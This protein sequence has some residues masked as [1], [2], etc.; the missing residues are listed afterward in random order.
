MV[1]LNASLA[2]TLVMII[3]CTMVTAVTEA[4]HCLF[5]MRQRGLKRMLVQLFD[6]AIWPR[7]EPLL[8]ERK[9]IVKKDFL[10]ALTGNPAVA[11]KGNERFWGIRTWFAPRELDSLT[12]TQLAEG[13]VDTKV[14]KKIWSCGREYA[15]QVVDDIARRFQRFE[16]GATAYFAQRAQMLSLLVAI[17]LAFMLNVD[18]VRLFSAFLSD[19]QLTAQVLAEG[20]NITAV[21]RQQEAKLAET[22]A[23]QNAQHAPPQPKSTVDTH[24]AAG[25]SGVTAADQESSDNAT[26]QA[27]KENLAFLNQQITTSTALGL[28]IG[29]AYYPWCL[30]NSRGATCKQTLSI[31]NVRETILAVRF[32]EWMISVLLTG[33]LIGLGGPFWFNAYSNLSAFIQLLRR[34][35]SQVKA[36][37]TNAAGGNKQPPVEVPQSKTAGESFATAAQAAEPKPG[38]PRILL[39]PQGTPL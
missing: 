18:A 5:G 1:W 32:A 14:G 35:D 38:Q 15:T 30:D 36:G 7:V 13:L 8:T 24:A 16:D 28:P 39:T 2:F 27:L 17:L 29:A 9:D 12:L 19:R 22:R 10:D 37:S 20:A 25:S 6:Q 33:F 4:I 31:S 3:F 21:Y 34:P 23:A 11:G 26:L